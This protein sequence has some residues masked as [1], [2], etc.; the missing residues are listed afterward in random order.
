DDDDAD[1]QVTMVEP[2]GSMLTNVSGRTTQVEKGALSSSSSAAT[3]IDPAAIEED[4]RKAV[5]MTKAG[6]AI[7]VR[8][9]F[10]LH[11][12]AVPASHTGKQQHDWDDLD[13]NDQR[14]PMMVSEYIHDIIAYMRTI[15]VQTLPSPDYMDKQTELTWSMRGI[16]VNWII[17]VHYQL[18]MF[19]ETLFLTVNIIDRFLSLRYVSVARLQLVGLTALLVASKYEEMASPSIHDLV[20]L[21]GNGYTEN[22]ILDA[23]IFMLRVIDFDMSY[24]S[25]MTFLRRV[26]KAENYNIQTRTVAKFLMEISLVDHRFL[27]F[28]PSQLAASAILLA[29]RMLS[30]G[31]WNANLRYYSGYTE[32]ELEPIVELYVEYLAM[33]CAHPALQKKYAH[34]RFLKASMFCREWVGRYY[35]EIVAKE[36]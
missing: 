2:V 9:G 3:V 15:E 29:R 17:Q 6:T 26:S 25:P 12:E 18:R 33:P 13:A 35:P 8:P 5:P 23:E 10:L 11:N 27:R 30:C 22:E 7:D 28:V 19:P 36:M 1:S 34:R 32:K 31:Q 4:A 20:Y 14:D 24:P 16:L 21:A